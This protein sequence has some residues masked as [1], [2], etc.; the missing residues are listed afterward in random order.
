R[1]SSVR[2]D[3]TK[4]I[5]MKKSLLLA[6]AA[7]L[8]LSSAATAATFTA[9][10]TPGIIPQTG[11]TNEV[12]DNV[13]GMPSTRGLFGSTVSISDAATIDVNYFGYEA[14]FTNSFSITGTSGTVAFDTDDNFFVN[15]GDPVNSNNS[16]Y[17]LDEMT[18]LSSQSITV[19]AGILDFSFMTSGG[20][21]TPAHTVDNDPLSANA[22]TDNTATP[23]IANFFTSISADARTVFLFFDDAGG[24]DDDNHDDFVVSL[25]LVSGQMPEPV[26]LPAGGLLLLGGLGAFAMARRRKTKA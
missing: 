22:N 26:P 3:T 13:F 7:V 9:G 6:G 25:S 23:A 10:G 2:T 1:S 12:L 8:A 15:P 11:Q 18:P 20:G 5:M 21:S 16:Y 4:V 14:G 17:A 24:G 19:A